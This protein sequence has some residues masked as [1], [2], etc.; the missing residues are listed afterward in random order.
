[1]NVNI[2]QR[3]VNFVLN[4]FCS[5]C[6]FKFQFVRVAVNK[7]YSENKQLLQNKSQTQRK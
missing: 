2:F 1:M 5:S 4:I 3:F 6:K 7:I